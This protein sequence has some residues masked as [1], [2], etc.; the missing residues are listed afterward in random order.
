IG[1]FLPPTLKRIFIDA[2][3][4]RYDHLIDCDSLLEHAQDLD[5]QSLLPVINSY[6]QAIRALISRAEEVAQQQIEKTVKQASAEMM[7]HYTTEIKRMQ[8]L[9]KHNPSVRS[10]EID[11]LQDQGLSLHQHLQ[12]A[13]LRLDAVRLVVTV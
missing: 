10:E 5:R 12:S 9:K 6:R 3:G 1:R 11:L 13:R 2:K 7:S 4:T 8:A